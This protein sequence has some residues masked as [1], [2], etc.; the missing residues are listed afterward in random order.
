MTGGR[1]RKGYTGIQSGQL[2]MFILELNIYDFSKKISRILLTQLADIRE[3]QGAREG[4]K[5]A[6]EKVY[7]WIRGGGSQSWF[8]LYLPFNTE[9]V[10][11]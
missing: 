3:P 6:E 8:I 11:V 7:K 10:F 5:G 4:E 2:G 9:C 1:N